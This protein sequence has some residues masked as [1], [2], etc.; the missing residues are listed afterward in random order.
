ML[1]GPKDISSS[2]I[3][4]FIARQHHWHHCPAMGK[5]AHP[6]WGHRG[7]G[8]GCVWLWGTCGMSLYSHAEEAQHHRL[9]CGS[10]ST[11]YFCPGVTGTNRASSELK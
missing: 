1:L 7:Q 8:W 2:P 5:K 9:N 6:Q 10:I 4:G 3:F 11:N